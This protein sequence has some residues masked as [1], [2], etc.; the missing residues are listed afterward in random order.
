M[1]WWKCAW[2]WKRFDMHGVEVDRL[3]CAADAIDRSPTRAKALS[4]LDL[5]TNAQLAIYIVLRYKSIGRS[6]PMW[7]LLVI[8]ES[9][10]LIVGSLAAGIL[11]C[12]SLWFIFKLLRHPAWGP[13]IVVAPALLALAGK[14]PHS[15]FLQLS[16]V[17]SVVAV[18]QCLQQLQDSWFILDKKHVDHCTG[19]SPGKLSFR[20]MWSDLAA[21]PIAAR[22]RC[23]VRPLVLDRRTRNIPIGAEHATVALE[24]TQHR[25]TM[26]TVIK[27]LACVGRH[28]FARPSSALGASEGRIKLGHIQKVM[29]LVAL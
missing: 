10:G 1:P 13:P 8:G 28:H 6:R 15:E 12:W 9:I 25:A 14:L 17:F 5:F 26:P 7:A 4:F 20:P 29:S 22:W 18:N 23:A 2:S 16:L 19:L 24:R 21:I 3:H 27:E 11:L